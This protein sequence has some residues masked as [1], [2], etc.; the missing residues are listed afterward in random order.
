MITTWSASIGVRPQAV[1]GIDPAVIACLAFGIRQTIQNTE[2]TG[3]RWLTVYHWD[4][5][6]MRMHDMLRSLDN[7]C[8]PTPRTRRTL[9]HMLDSRPCG[10]GGRDTWA[11]DVEIKIAAGTPAFG[12][13]TLV[14][15]GTAADMLGDVDV[16][17]PLMGD[18]TIM[19]CGLHKKGPQEAYAILN[20]EGWA[21]TI[22]GQYA[23]LQRPPLPKER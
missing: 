1:I 20:Q 13:V 9:I 21:G 2:Y 23:F 4:A 18:T 17:A 15:I 8:P 7:V 19:L 12:L 16:L 5:G 6:Y 3:R 10:E 22:N 14:G 11:R